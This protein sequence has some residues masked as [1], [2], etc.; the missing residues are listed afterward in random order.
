[1]TLL[2]FSGESN[3][4]RRAKVG[5]EREREG[6]GER[7]RGRGRSWGKERKEKKSLFSLSFSPALL[8]VSLSFRLLAPRMTAP[9][10]SGRGQRR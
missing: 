10:L 2:E 8:L 9:P 6:R 4:N 5:G 7:R 3:K 1:V